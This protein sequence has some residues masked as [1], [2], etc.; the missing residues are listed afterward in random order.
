VTLGT[1]GG[2]LFPGWSKTI[3]VAGPIAGSGG[4]GIAWDSGT[5][6]L[7]GSN[8]YQ[9]ATTIGTT[10]KLYYD[11]AGAN[12]TL[13]VGNANALPAGSALVFGTSAQN[14]TATLDL[15]GY[16]A[17]VGGMTGSS[18]A[19]VT[20][21]G[22]GAST[23][24]VSVASGTST[25]G[26]QISSG[27]GGVA[28]VKTGAGALQL[29]GSTGYTGT[30]TI[31]QGTLAL[32]GSGVIADVSR[33]VMSAGA[34]LDVGT[35]QQGFEG[36]SGTGGTIVL[37]NG[38]QLALNASTPSSTYTFGGTI[39]GTGDLI[40]Q[41]I[42][43]QI[44]TGTSLFTGTTFI[45]GG[46]L[47]ATTSSLQ[48]PVTN[49]STLEVSQG[50]TGS[51]AGAISGTGSVTKSGVG[52]AIFS[53]TSTYTGPT[54]VSGG[55]LSVNG[56]LG[57]TAVTVHSN[58]EL[59]GSGSIVGALAVLAGGTLAPGNSIAS[60][61]G[62]A[63]SF[64]A[65][66]TFG[67]E[68]DSSL[69]GSLGT[70]ADLLVV[71]GNLDIAAGSILSFTDLASTVQPFVPTSTVF[72]LINYSGAWNG[73]LFAYGGTPLADG[74]TFTVGSQ[75]WIIDYTSSTGGLNYTSDYLP[76]SS[77]VTVTAVPEPSSLILAGLG[78][79]AAAWAARRRRSSA[80]SNGDLPNRNPG[81]K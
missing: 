27:T 55:R 79:A 23:L 16:S 6:I 17:S 1:A 9:G 32:S 77:F 73:G 62:G 7:S 28:V 18:N 76:S 70:A 65:G 36:V 57:N 53:G 43:T 66:S 42:G 60:L 50:S 59:G 25:Y 15:N 20:N 24:T 72:A 74:S 69:L 44:L 58:A 13:R 30:T 19:R 10:G 48:G 26:G 5:A 8:S 61:A 37:R 54:V 75:Q 51:F 56:A 68:V 38:T 12:P 64:A 34:T 2:Y 78:V 29:A 33:L 71:S 63:T 3:T 46:K 35:V 41:G 80:A 67:Y 47:V 45:T 40:K 49:F 39:T 11:N 21:T 52:N 31:E 4:L 81:V 14:N 22:T